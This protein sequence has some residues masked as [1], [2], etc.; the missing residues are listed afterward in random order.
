M[1][2]DKRRVPPALRGKKILQTADLIG[3]AG[4]LGAAAVT[5]QFNTSAGANDAVVD[6]VDVAHNVDDLLDVADAID[7][8]FDVLDWF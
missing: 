1:S 2:D 3:A 5:T 4:A 6:Y 8:F 7:T